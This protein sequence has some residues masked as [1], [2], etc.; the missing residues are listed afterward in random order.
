VGKKDG[1]QAGEGILDD[2]EE[3]SCGRGLI[4]LA[5]TQAFENGTVGQQVGDRRG[6]GL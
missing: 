2:L 4:S 6:E 1:G 3:E 5:N